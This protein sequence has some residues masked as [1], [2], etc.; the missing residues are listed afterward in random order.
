VN[1]TVPP[2]PASVLQRPRAIGLDL[3]G[4]LVDSAP[5]IAHAA[6]LT[7]AE[8]GLPVLAPARIRGM[9]GDGIDALLERCLAAACA[10][11]G[12]G[13][14]ADAPGERGTATEAAAL[15]QAARPVLQRHYAQHVYERGHIFPG[16][17]EALRRWCDEGIALVCITNKASRFAL[18]LLQRSGLWPYLE[19]C[20]CADLPEERKPAPVLINRCLLERGLAPEEL[21]LIGDSCHDLSAAS[22]A[23]CP[24]VAVSYGYG[25]ATRLAAAGRPVLARLDDLAFGREADRG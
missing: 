21:L 17:L 3:D 18:P 6:N 4:T 20:Y 15:F 16:V 11:D 12:A 25:D 10:D 23:G 7:L 19:A 22:A 5:D 9:I 8:L 24:S 2:D 14:D 13:A 1:A